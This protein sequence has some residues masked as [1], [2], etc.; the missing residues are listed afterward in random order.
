[1]A[2]QAGGNAGAV[3]IYTYDLVIDLTGLDPATASIAGT[4]GTDNDGSISLNRMLNTARA[5]AGITLVAG[6]PMSIVEICSVDGWKCSEPRSSSA[7][8]KA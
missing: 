5:V 8:V 3:G 7:L 1:M 2:P 4:F 6:L